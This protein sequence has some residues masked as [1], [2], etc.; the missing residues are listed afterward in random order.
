MWTV[1]FFGLAYRFLYK[2]MGIACGVHAYLA[3]EVYSYFTKVF[4]T[5]KSRAEKQCFKKAVSSVSDS[6]EV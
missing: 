5:T 4:N 1:Q 3:N 2:Y 6:F